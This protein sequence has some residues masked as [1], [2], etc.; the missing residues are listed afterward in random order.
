MNTSIN[1]TNVA[2][3]TYIFTGTVRL[4]QPF[5]TCSADLAKAAADGAT[6]VPVMWLDNARHGVIP[7]T[8]IKGGM[9][10]RPAYSYIRQSVVDTTGNATPYTLEEFY[11]N[12][13]GGIKS[14]EENQPNSADD[15]AG[16][17]AKNP[18]L[19]L[20]GAGAAGYL[21][22]VPGRLCVGNAITKKPMR[23][24]VASGAR[25]DDFQNDKYE[26][27]YLSD[28]ECAKYFTQSALT[29]AKSKNNKKIEALEVKI[30]EAK[31]K[32]QYEKVAELELQLD[33]LYKDQK[34]NPDKNSVAMPLAG[35]KAI[36]QGTE[37][38]HTMRI[39][40][41]T[42]VE[43]GCLMAA[44][45]EFALNK[46]FL[47]AHYANGNGLIEAEWE[48]AVAGKNYEA[49]TVIGSVIMKPDHALEIVGDTL[50]QAFDLFNTKLA[51]GEFDLT[52]PS[53][54]KLTGKV[55]RKAKTAPMAPAAPE[56]T[57]A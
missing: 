5:A 35:W 8:G 28:E 56:A 1:L 39:T 44:I 6:P 47:G 27:E 46:P 29:K 20:F 12:A 38:D 25:K 23:E 50:K 30:K 45:S 51:A 32:E 40:K 37:L 33:E 34:S 14:K 16:W 3:A 52:I 10:R 53:A 9:L 43:L 57:E 31:S 22:M 7:S 49:P 21:N 54:E 13:I 42:L 17:R 41:G 26:M 36:P 11:F 19:S 15:I 4:L 2:T 55:A 18:I 48:V 24:Y